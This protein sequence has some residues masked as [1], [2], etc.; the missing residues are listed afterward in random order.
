MPLSEKP[1][2]A[3]LFIQNFL[4]LSLAW[5]LLSLPT[6]RTLILNGVGVLSLVILETN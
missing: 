4:P 5:G 6:Q 3:A 1:N 2:G